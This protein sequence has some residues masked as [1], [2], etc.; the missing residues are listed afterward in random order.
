MSLF[1]KHVT[2]SFLSQ[3][4]IFLHQSRFP[5]TFGCGSSVEFTLLPRRGGGG[6]EELLLDNLKTSQIFKEEYSLLHSPLR[7]GGGG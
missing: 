7:C 5:S 2:L 1:L 6:R 4:F 3:K